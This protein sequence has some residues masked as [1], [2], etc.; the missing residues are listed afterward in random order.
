MGGRGTGLGF[1][2]SSLASVCEEWEGRGDLEARR[3]SPGFCSVWGTRKGSLGTGR[4]R[5]SGGRGASVTLR[6]IFFF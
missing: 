1:R 6:L 2:K 3:V 4:G 5:A